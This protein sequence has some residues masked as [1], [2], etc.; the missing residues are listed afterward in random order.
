[1]NHHRSPISTPSAAS[2][3]ALESRF[4]FRVSARLSERSALV[5][6]DVAER[7]RFAREQAIAR[8]RA[9]HTAAAAPAAVGITAGGSALLGRLGGGWWFR[10]ASA[11]PAFA[12]VGGLVL[13]QHWQDRTQIAVAAEVDAALLADTLPPTAY[14]DAGFVE[15]L[16][17]P[18][19]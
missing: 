17:T 1:M 11:L 19:E 16:K 13:I 15:Y 14:S 2:L 6:P 4:A 3:D 9:G 7:L 18:R 5:G 8:A 10:L 12:L